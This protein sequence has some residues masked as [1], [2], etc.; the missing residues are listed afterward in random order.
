MLAECSEQA[1]THFLIKHVQDILVRA[2]HQHIRMRRDD[3]D[4]PCGSLAGP[5][6]KHF[7]HTSWSDRRIEVGRLLDGTAQV[8]D[9]V[10]QH[11]NTLVEACSNA[12]VEH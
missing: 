9:F 8:L 7:Y 10:H 6:I 2:A 3:I 1:H 4:Y 12:L 11:I 5:D